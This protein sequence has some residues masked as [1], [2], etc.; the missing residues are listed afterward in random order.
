MKTLCLGMI[1]LFLCEFGGIKLMQIQTPPAAAQS[2]SQLDAGKKINQT[3]RKYILIFV[4]PG[5]VGRHIIRAK[6][7][8]SMYHTDGKYVSYTNKSE[9]CA[10][11]KECAWERGASQDG[12]L[13]I[14]VG[15]E[16][17]W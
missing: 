16:G 10:V 6:Q 4:W 7:N 12:M 5:N 9:H 3:T 1:C 13:G 2:W 11:E 17:G 14:R 8:D 15:Q